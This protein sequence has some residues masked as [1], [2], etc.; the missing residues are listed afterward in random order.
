MSLR[1]ST[2]N[3]G[4][5]AFGFGGSFTYLFHAHAIV[6]SKASSSFTCDI[7]SMIAHTFPTWTSNCLKFLCLWKS[8]AAPTLD[9][10][11][12]MLLILSLWHIQHQ[13]VRYRLADA[14]KARTLGT[15]AVPCAP[16]YPD[17]PHSSVT[18]S[19]SSFRPS[20]LTECGQGK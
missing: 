7:S 8:E 9:R 6:M 3:T 12:L 19:P 14:S 13:R 20:E 5:T 16:Q 4:F 17:A 11:A 15:F 10:R 18:A 1:S 2:F